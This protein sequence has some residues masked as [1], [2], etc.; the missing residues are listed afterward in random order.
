MFKPRRFTC[1]VFAEDN[2]RGYACRLW[3]I[4][5]RLFGIKLSFEVAWDE[6]FF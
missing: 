3:V 5:I 2:S 1:G 6:E 4:A